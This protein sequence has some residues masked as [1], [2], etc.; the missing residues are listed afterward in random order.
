MADV[1]SATS[2]T[3]VNASQAAKDAK[4]ADKSP[5]KPEFTEVPVTVKLR[6]E[7]KSG[8]MVD[9]ILLAHPDAENIILEMFE[10]QDDIENPSKFS[11]IV[12]FDALVAFAKIR[13]NAAA[14]D[15]E[16]LLDKACRLKPTRTR[17]D[18][19]RE[20]L[21]SR[22]AQQFKNR[23]VAAAALKAKL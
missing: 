16:R 20:L 7:T 18:V 13:C 2:T 9:A 11:R 6:K 1:T 17:D 3:P 8:E 5:A 14:A 23:A 4:P 15:Y 21:E 12:I 22:K 19:E 10:I